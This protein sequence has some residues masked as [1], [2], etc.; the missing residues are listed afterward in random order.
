MLIVISPAKKIDMLP[1]SSALKKVTQP[2]FSD[3]S[4]ELVKQLKLL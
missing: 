3:K 1:E 4:Q 2:L